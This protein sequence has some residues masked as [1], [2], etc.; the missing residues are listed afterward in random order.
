M[1]KKGRVFCSSDWHGCWDPAYRVIEYLKPDDKLYFLGDA[2]DRGPDGIK[3][4]QTLI[5]D[6]RITFIKGNHEEMMAKSIPFF[7]SDYPQHEIYYNWLSNGGDITSQSLEK[8]TKEEVYAIKEAVNKMPTEIEY[9]SPTGHKIIM[10]HA[11]YTPF[12]IPNKTHDP[13]WDRSHF[14]DKWSNKEE[15]SNPE[16]NK[17]YLIHG[18]TPTAYLKYYYGYNNMP[19]ITKRDNIEKRQFFKNI[20]LDGEEIIKPEV[21]CYCDGHKFDVDLCTVVSGRIALIDLDTF[22]IIYFDKE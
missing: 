21:I 9:T 20:V 13:L 7:Y 1:E 8:M 19:K 10:E 12:G 5:N 3:I 11:G 4:F 18:H 17:T 15:Q 22:E 14:H 2:I 6:P 16:I